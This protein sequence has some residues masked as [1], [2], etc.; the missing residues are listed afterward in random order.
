MRTEGERKTRWS[1]PE[2]GD[3]SGAASALLLLCLMAGCTPASGGGAGGPRGDAGPG[4][5]EGGALPST[6]A[7]SRAASLGPH[8][9]LDAVMDEV[10]VGMDEGAG[11]ERLRAAAAGLQAEIVGGIPEIAV[12]QLR[13][14]NDGRDGAVLDAMLSAAAEADGISFAYPNYRVDTFAI[15]PDDGYSWEGANDD[16]ACSRA[17]NRV[18]IRNQLWGL[19][20]IGMPDAWSLATGVAE[21]PIAVVD[22]GFRVDHGDFG[23]AAVLKYGDDT[24]RL[25]GTHVAGIAGARGNNGRGVAGVNWEAPLWLYAVE[26]TPDNENLPLLGVV[27]EAMMRAFLDG[28]GVINLSMGF[29]W[30]K[31][32]ICPGEEQRGTIEEVQPGWRRVLGVL[33]RH[34]VL[35]I[36]AAGND[37]DPRRGCLA[38]AWFSGPQSLVDEFPNTLINVASV[39]QPRVPAGDHSYY[40]DWAEQW[41][42]LSWY[43]SVGDGVDVAAPGAEILSL[44][45][46]GRDGVVYLSGTSMAAPYVTGLASLIRGIRPELSSGQVKARI[47]EGARRRGARVF[48]PLDGEAVETLDTYVIQAAE[49]LAIVDRPGG[50]EDRDGDG[51]G[52]A[53]EGAVGLACPEQLA[54]C[55]DAEAAAHPGA[56]ELCDGIDNNCNGH[57]DEENVCEGILV[58]APVS[59]VVPGQ[60]DT[61]GGEFRLSVSPLDPNGDLVHRELSERSFSFRDIAVERLEAPGV[62]VAEGEATPTRIEVILPGGAEDALRLVLLLD[63]S[64]SMSGSDPDYTRVRASRELVRQ[65]DDDD[66]VAVMDFGADGGGGG[67]TRLLSPMSGDRADTDAGLGRVTAEG[68]TPMFRAVIEAVDYLSG[69]DG[70]R[71]VLVLL[72]DGQA[73]GDDVALADQAVDAARES[74]VAVYAVGLGDS[75]DFALLET[76]GEQTGGTFAFARDAGVLVG[77][78]DAIGV[79]AAA[80]RIVVHGAGHFMPS[81]P[82][83]GRHLVRGVLRTALGGARVDTPFDFTVDVR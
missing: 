9:G 28:A 31:D 10:L 47:V 57:V 46:D 11:E 43:S 33:E 82:E 18:D 72:S 12:W 78:F 50:C 8:R 1:A 27:Q 52:S 70:G 16:C 71:R 49:S 48:R 63:S 73:D 76:L 20:A 55:D 54:D 59:G 4:A 15:Y 34:D 44:S 25:H 23:G 56:V 38:D 62:V 19:N 41:N 29:N 60:F 81:L 79:A 80:G 3:G 53:A 22:D 35:L 14:D 75:L 83:R 51:F 66:E 24:R 61:N 6:I 77:L 68:G 17:W 45:D 42:A 74:D 65:L 40:S 37:S 2:R 13:F 39:G 67:V 21:N 7:P 64:G 5:P 30:Y 36:A 69:V 26:G 32:G 58:D